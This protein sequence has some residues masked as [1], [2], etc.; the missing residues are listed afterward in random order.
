MTEDLQWNHLC[1]L[2]E[3]DQRLEDVQKLTDPEKVK[4]MIAFLRAD[5][6]LMIQKADDA[7]AAF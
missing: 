5:L 1:Q 7:Y 3:I 6:Y 2:E 4:K